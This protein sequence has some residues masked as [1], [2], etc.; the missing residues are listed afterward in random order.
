MG[1]LLANRVHSFQLSNGY[2]LYIEFR[3]FKLSCKFYSIYILKPTIRTY[4]FFILQRKA[5][6]KNA[7]DKV[8]QRLVVWT[9]QIQKM[10]LRKQTAIKV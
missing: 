6:N 3:S 10:K 9:L 1:E 2:K 4:I 5:N 8:P 7:R